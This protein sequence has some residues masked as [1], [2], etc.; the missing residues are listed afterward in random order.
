[1]DITT[2]RKRRNNNHKIRMIFLLLTEKPGQVKPRLLA[3][4]IIVNVGKIV[5]AT[6]KDRFLLT[7]YTIPSSMEDVLS[8]AMTETIHVFGTRLTALLLDL[9]SKLTS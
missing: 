8:V 1:M 4:F 9:K 5:M 2:V 7:L 6:M 3:C